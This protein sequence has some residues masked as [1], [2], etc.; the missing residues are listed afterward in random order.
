MIRS[1]LTGAIDYAGLFPPA[2]LTMPD[3]VRNYHHYRQSP[4]A[5][6]LGRFVVRTAQLDE[7]ASAAAGL[8]LP[9][10]RGG[11]PWRLSALVS[12]DG[13][14]DLEAIL[15]FNALHTVAATGGWAGVVDT[16]EARAESVEDV[17]AL[18]LSRDPSIEMFV[19]VGPSDTAA[20][21]LEALAAARL[22][23]KIRTGGVTPDQ[24]PSPMQVARFLVECGRLGLPF[25]ATA[26]LHHPVRADYPLTYAADS[27][28]GTMF[29]FLNVLL[30]AAAARD[31]ASA[32]ELAQL[33]D[34]R[35]PVAL[36]I[37]PRGAAWRDRRFSTEDI[38]A[39]RTRFALSFGSCSF[40]EPLAD[41]RALGLL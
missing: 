20:R 38:E 19:E 21:L 6:A 27:E 34:E 18:A 15:G 3:A 32:I 36:G 10:A 33:L 28:R 1:L 39:V 30:A 13:A 5:W 24:V 12:G 17:D 14:A 2:G 35:D 4:D 16:V 26:G 7:L 25:K 37:G 9:A 41:L 8:P 31:G 22:A 29:G 23:A 11:A 40:E